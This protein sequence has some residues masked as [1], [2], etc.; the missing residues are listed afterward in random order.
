MF[1]GRSNKVARFFRATRKKRQSSFFA[2][3]TGAGAVSFALALPALLGV[4][5]VATDF[6]I[7]NYK[8]AQLQNA[9]DQAAIAAVKEF[10]VANSNSSSILSAAESYAHSL[11]LDS[12]STI[13]VK[14]EVDK[15]KD[16]VSVVL[17]EHWT[18]FFAH[19]FSSGVTPIVADAKASLAG[20]TNLCVLALDP[21]DD[22]AFHMDKSAL[23]QAN[24]CAVYSN[25]KHAEGLRLDRNSEL[26]AASICSVGGVF[27]R[28]NAV[29]PTP[30]TDCAV[31]ED[32]LA[33]RAAPV[34]GS[35]DYTNIEIVSG[36]QVLS[37][38]RYCGGIKVSGDAMVTFGTGDYIVSDGNLEVSGDAAVVG[39]NVAFYLHGAKS[40]LQLTGNTTVS[41]TG[42]KTGSMA[43][44][45][46]FED[47]SVKLGRRHRINSANARKLTGTIYMSRGRL[48]VD[49]NTPVAQDSAYT[50]IVV[51]RLE[52]NEGPTLVMNT[53]YGASNVPVPDGIRLDTQVVLSK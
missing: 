26:N 19:F 14:V 6:G 50:A 20:K 25:S 36:S 1:V 27:A 3:T 24:G 30:T 13:D 16:G 31:I 10:A 35:C 42:A 43:G 53:N 41:L 22:K 33:G 12:G 32:P 23:L 48:L 38:G 15:S 44:L 52:I 4:V 5:G 28:T 9:A 46:F 11:V 45:L 47:R 49:P 34:I 37:P 18:P 17:T 8:K 39:E 51:H 2:N 29:S 7:V 21:I 40:T